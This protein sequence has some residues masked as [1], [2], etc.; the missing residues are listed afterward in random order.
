MEHET[1]V[2]L[3]CDHIDQ[4][5]DMAAAHQNA[6]DEVSKWICINEM[7]DLAR[8]MDSDDDL[9]FMTYHR[10]LSDNFGVEFEIDHGDEE[11]MF[12]GV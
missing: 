4:L 2:E 5:S 12:G 3:A 6:G 8:A 7:K 9:F 10:Y 11:L 1:L